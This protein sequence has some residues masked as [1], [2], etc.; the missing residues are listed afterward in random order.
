MKNILVITPVKHIENIVERLSE[1][2]HL[3]IVDD[4]SVADLHKLDFKPHVLFTNPNKSKVY[5]GEESLQQF[6][7]LECI[8]TA[9]TG[10]VHIDL[11][12]C[13]RKGIAVISITK[14]LDT[15]KEISSTAELALLA[16]LSACRSYTQCVSDARDKN[17]WDYEQYIGRQI[18]KRNIGVIGYGRLGEMYVRYMQALGANIFVYEIDK[19]K[20]VDGAINFV[21]SLGEVFEKCDIVS[22]HCHAT[23]DNLNLINK[24]LLALSQKNLILVNTARGEIVNEHDIVGYLNKNPQ[25]IYATDVIA[26]ESE[27]R[28]ESPLY[29]DLTNPGQL[30]LSQHIGG[31]TSDAQRMAYNRAVDLLVNWF[32]QAC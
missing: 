29:N 20:R 22:L 30:I 31:M 18:N 7:S 11:D 27:K 23:E 19:A 9:S 8:V 4:P 13:N 25:A 15:L 5:L 10:L 28:T 16:T 32:N 1:L 24:E 2:G 6:E 21:E 14:E 17:N 26:Y 3:F 12:Y